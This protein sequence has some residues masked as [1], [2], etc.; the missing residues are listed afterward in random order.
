M[1]GQ[2]GKAAKSG[3]SF[4]GTGADR[5]RTCTLGYIVYQEAGECLSSVQAALAN[6]CSGGYAIEICTIQQYI[7]TSIVQLHNINSAPR[8]LP[9]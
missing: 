3:S 4:G 8:F 7:L 5:L 2:E 9:S 6:Y 1:C